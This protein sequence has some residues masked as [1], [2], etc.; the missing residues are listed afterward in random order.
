MIL[1]HF[2]FLFQ[3]ETAQTSEL[4]HPG[5]NRPKDK[6]AKA[7][8]VSVYRFDYHSIS[9]NAQYSNDKELQNTFLAVE[10]FVFL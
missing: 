5:L 10:I 3:A 8:K 2:T 7:E 4:R 6:V 9:E 1:L